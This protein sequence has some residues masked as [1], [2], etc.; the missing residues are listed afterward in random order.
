MNQNPGSRL[1]IVPCHSI[2][3]AFYSDSKGLNF[4][5]LPDH[6]FLAPFQFEGNDHLAFINHGLSAI[7]ALVND[8]LNDSVVVF[9]GSQTKP[10]AG[11]ISEA[12]SYYLLMRKLLQETHCN[13]STISTIFNKEITKRLKDI[14]KTL[15]QHEISI[16][17]LFTHYITT[18]EFALDSFENLLFSIYRFQQVKTKFPENITIVG[19]G[20]KKRRF[21]E[22]H[23][24]AIDFPIENMEYIAIDPLPSGYTP[25]ELRRYIE[26]LNTLELRNALELFAADWYGTQDQLNS[27]KKSRNPFKRFDAY[28]NV[29]L[30]PL[31]KA[32]T[33]N[34]SFFENYIKDV[35]PW[36]RHKT[37]TSIKV[38]K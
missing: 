38:I 12:Q 2:W 18:E 24:K 8:F 27:K 21:L 9:S 1:I 6:W 36:S 37:K 13:E 22:Y 11:C 20:F 34:R 5:Q 33:D 26:E 7:Q 4:G 32:I 15:L 16:E 35:M 10:Q 23:A 29:S 31:N 19:F 3:N 25:D 14:E 17:E 30:F 28:Q